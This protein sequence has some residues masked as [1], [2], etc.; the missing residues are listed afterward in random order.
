MVRGLLS[1][2]G[3]LALLSGGTF[4]A[5]ERPSWLPVFGRT[6]Q[7]MVVLVGNRQAVERVRSAV[8]PER[9]VATSADAIALRGGWIVAA[10]PE[11]V[12]APYRAAGWMDREIAFLHVGRAD[13]SGARAGSA[14]DGSDADRDD[15]LARLHELA[16]KPTLSAGEQMFVLQAMNDGMEL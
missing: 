8:T 14:G 2:F 5:L 11:S 10:N 6:P 12:A 13:W 15:R 1:L 3:C 9:L 4:L 7:V 16:K